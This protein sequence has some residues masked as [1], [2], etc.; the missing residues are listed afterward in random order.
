MRVLL[1]DTRCVRYRGDKGSA[2]TLQEEKANLFL[3]HLA[4]PVRTKNTAHDGK[5]PI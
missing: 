5:G 1:S 2:G 4:F 3:K